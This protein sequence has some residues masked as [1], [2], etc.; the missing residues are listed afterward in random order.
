MA[1]HP[2]QNPT[3]PQSVDPLKFENLPSPAHRG[4]IANI[5]SGVMGK[6]EIREYSGLLGVSKEVDASYGV[7]V[8]LA[9]YVFANWGTYV[10]KRTKFGQNDNTSESPFYNCF[11]Y[12]D[13]SGDLLEGWA[14]EEPKPGAWR[15]YETIENWTTK[16]LAP[17]L[18][19]TDLTPNQRIFRNVL[20]GDPVRSAAT[21]C[22]EGQPRTDQLQRLKAAVS[23]PSKNP[24]HTYQ[25]LV[26]LIGRHF[27]PAPPV[28]SYKQSSNSWLET[29][30][31]LFER[32]RIT[33]SSLTPSDGRLEEGSLRLKHDLGY[34]SNYR[35]TSEIVTRLTSRDASDLWL[36]GKP[37]SVM[38]L[39]MES[40][41]YTANPADV[42]ECVWDCY[43][44][45]D[46]ELL[47]SDLGQ[48]KFQDLAKEAVRWRFN[49]D[50]NS[51]CQLYNTKDGLPRFL[52]FVIDE[53]IGPNEPKEQHRSRKE[54]FAELK[55][56]RTRQPEAVDPERFDDSK[57]FLI[58]RFPHKEKAYTDAMEVLLKDE[59]ICKESFTIGFLETLFFSPEWQRELW[60]D[61]PW[62]SS[63]FD[64]EG[65]ESHLLPFVLGKLDS[66][67]G[68][69]DKSPEEVLRDLANG[70]RS[71]LHNLLVYRAPETVQKLL[72]LGLEVSSKCP[73]FYDCPPL[74]YIMRQAVIN[75]HRMHW[76][77]RFDRI[78]ESIRLMIK[79]GA[80]PKAVDESVDVQEFKL[81]A[82][83]YASLD[84]RLKPL[85]GALLW[86][87]ET[88]RDATEE[89]MVD[90]YA[91]DETF[92]KSQ[93][94]GSPTS[95]AEILIR[96]NKDP[97]N[98]PDLR[99]LHTMDPS[100]SSLQAN[101]LSTKTIPEKWQWRKRECDVEFEYESKNEHY[102][103]P[104]NLPV[105]FDDPRPEKDYSR[106]GEASGCAVP[107]ASYQ[108][109]LSPDP[110]VDS[111]LSSL[112]AWRAGRMHSSNFY[113]YSYAS[114]FNHP[115]CDTRIW[116]PEP[117]A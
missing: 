74:T 21:S 116:A 102:R 65:G 104:L 35:R 58:L 6:G 30:R 15:D 60:I 91:A 27:S 61:R 4:I 59:M 39:A 83:M 34:F 108:S 11:N 5:Q 99:V 63:W 115:G 48:E 90:F 41:F 75:R 33:V 70:G 100:T 3:A 31:Y 38:E 20:L 68:I 107:T 64:Y 111:R 94:R 1:D 77:F 71:F 62:T 84:L 40:T 22:A 23:N 73:G 96:L 101:F 46:K 45:K 42:I 57:L 2:V 54:A 47:L 86:N 8:A 85:L 114:L 49:I 105:E 18:S 82:I 97:R 7:A 80:D 95:K 89:E 43:Y 109:L 10:Y 12:F 69:D 79:A 26:V 87:R 72:D 36:F 55:A 93:G 37:I 103:G 24:I 66:M 28:D 78:V 88:Q 16:S 98:L 113:G 52:K 19:L 13:A 51:F 50:R 53:L 56:M 44:R 17:E 14:T 112:W 81:N 67:G 117:A 106:P 32:L 110:E 92:W 29:A 76:S 25:L 9:S